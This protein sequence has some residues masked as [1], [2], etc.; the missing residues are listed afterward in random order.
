[1][2]LFAHTS[3]PTWSA[4][5]PHWSACTP[6]LLTYAPLAFSLLAALRWF[7]QLCHC[8]NLLHLHFNPPTLR[9]PFLEYILEIGLHMY[10]KIR[11]RKSLPPVDAQTHGAYHMYV[12]TVLT[13]PKGKKSTPPVHARTH[14]LC[15]SSRP[16]KPL[17]QFPLPT[18]QPAH[19]P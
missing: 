8:D 7:I 13:L 3:T 2:S 9:G 12:R 10:L 5:T 14:G 19:P 6:H 1:V 17:R 18:L 16:T 15:W 11:V 4:C